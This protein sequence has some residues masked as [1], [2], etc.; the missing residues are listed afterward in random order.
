[1]TVPAERVFGAAKAYEG[2]TPAAASATLTAPMTIM[3]FVDDAIA[4]DKLY[5][6]T[7]F[8]SL[9]T[10]RPAAPSFAS[11]RVLGCRTVQSGL[12][13][14]VWDHTFTMSLPKKAVAE[15]LLFAVFGIIGTSIALQHL[16]LVWPLVLIYGT[17]VWKGYVSHSLVSKVI[18]PHTLVQRTLHLI[19]FLLHLSLAL[20]FAHPGYFSILMLALLLV[21]TFAYTLRFPLAQNPASLFRKIKINTIEALLAL[22]AFMGVF[23]EYTQFTLVMW[24]ILLVDIS[25]YTILLRG[26][27]ATPSPA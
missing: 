5:R 20:S 10:T 8:L 2:S 16:L 18:T 26:V 21:E 17:M 22:F 25:V 13:A 6:K 19:L 9:I 11:G 27:Y 14:L 1:M 4:S 12:V 3:F 15:V 24:G 23:F 7:S